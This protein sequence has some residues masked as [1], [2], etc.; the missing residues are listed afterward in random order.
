[1]TKPLTT[2]IHQYL[3]NKVQINSVPILEEQFAQKRF[4]SIILNILYH[5]E[6]SVRTAILAHYRNQYWAIRDIAREKRP[7]EN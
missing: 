6:I 4:Q 7:G 3:V 1:M 5:V 2:S